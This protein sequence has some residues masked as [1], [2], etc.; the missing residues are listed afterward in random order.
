MDGRFF[1]KWCVFGC[2]LAAGAGCKSKQ[3]SLI[4][5]TGGEPTKLVNMPIGGNNS[6]SLWGGSHGPTMPVEVEPE[7]SKKPASAASLVAIA[8]VQ[9]DAAFDE[10]TASGSKEGLLDSARNYYQK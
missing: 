5:P 7:V 2:L 6:R 9:L 10:R 4:G 1:R 3:Q 8:D